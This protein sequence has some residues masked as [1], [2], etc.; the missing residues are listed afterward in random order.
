MYKQFLL[1]SN[2]LNV[3][4][5]EGEDIRTC[6]AGYEYA[7]YETGIFLTVVFAELLALDVEMSA[8]FLKKNTL[9]CFQILIQ[10]APLVI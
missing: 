3:W 5:P 4:I 10:K 1:T 2:N 7:R 9:F 6:I 8:G